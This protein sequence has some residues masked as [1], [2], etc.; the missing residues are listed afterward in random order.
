MHLLPFN[1]GRGFFPMKGSEEMG[2]HNFTVRLS[3]ETLMWL[4]EEAERQHRTVANL[5]NYILSLYRENHPT[6]QA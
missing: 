2:K 5:I 6:C 4:R 1:G 3:D